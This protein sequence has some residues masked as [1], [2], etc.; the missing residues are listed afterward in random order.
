MLPPSNRMAAH[1]KHPRHSIAHHTADSSES[2]ARA[3]D[4]IPG[5]VEKAHAQTTGQIHKSSQMSSP[6]PGLYHRLLSTVLWLAD[7]VER[8]LYCT[9]TH[10]DIRGAPSVSSCFLAITNAIHC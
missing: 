4:C 7:N 2:S 9:H 10:V 8:L 1:L 3:P 6:P 5:T